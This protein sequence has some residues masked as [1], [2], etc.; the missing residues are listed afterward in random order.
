MN[1][2]VRFL[3]VFGEG[4][5]SL[6]NNLGVFNHSER[7]QCCAIKEKTTYECVSTKK[8]RTG[9]EPRHEEFVLIFS[10]LSSDRTND[11][12]WLLPRHWWTHNKTTLTNLL[13]NYFWRKWT[14]WQTS[15][16]YEVVT[17]FIISFQFRCLHVHSNKMLRKLRRITASSC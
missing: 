2:N 9:N 7:K 14:S 8:Q 3:R 15:W 13:C 17:K 12:F 4:H 5:S 10:W 1:N 11:W 6:S 16:R